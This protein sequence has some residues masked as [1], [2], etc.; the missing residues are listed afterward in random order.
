MATSYE[1]ELLTIAETARLLK[2]S[3]ITIQRWLKVGRLAGVRVGPKAVRIR[4]GD[5]AQVM[6]P[7]APRPARS[8][9]DVPSTDLEIRPLTDEEVRRGLEALEASRRLGERILARRGGKLLDESW[10]MIREAREER[11][12]QL[13]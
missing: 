7:T 5:I 10:P 6:T 2:V 13:L 4:R 9:F 8:A 12:K 11:S 1:D 3:P